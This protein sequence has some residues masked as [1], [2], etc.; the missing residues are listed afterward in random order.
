MRLLCTL[1]FLVQLSIFVVAQNISECD[2]CW[3]SME[4]G[5]ILDSSGSISNPEFNKAKLFIQNFIGAFDIGPNAVRVAL[6]HYGQPVHEADAI[7]LSS[8]TNKS[9]LL[10]AIGQVTHWAT[11]YTATWNAI[12]FMREKQLNDS[13]VRPGLP[14]VCVVI[15]DGNSQVP[16]RTRTQAALTRA[17]NIT[18]FAIGVGQSIHDQEL[19]NIA[20]NISH[21]ATVD[22]FDQLHTIIQW[23]AKETCIGGQGRR[24]E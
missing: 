10:D 23:L 19:E 17:Q 9:A 2:Y 24:P 15:T 14:K 3:R 1:C 7:Y 22:N 5:I 13:C 6:V 11:L 20:G 8:Y 16:R 12:Q 4:L 18:M 21:V